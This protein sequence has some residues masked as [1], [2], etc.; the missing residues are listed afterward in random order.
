M[1]TVRT[2]NTNLVYVAFKDKVI[3]PHWFDGSE[4]ERNYEKMSSLHII[5]SALIYYL[6]CM[7]LSEPLI[8]GESV[9]QYIRGCM[10]E[11][12]V[13]CKNAASTRN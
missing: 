12:R 7:S 5:L 3:E 8:S 9:A 6:G 4:A 1:V 13:T 10:K 2:K 11:L